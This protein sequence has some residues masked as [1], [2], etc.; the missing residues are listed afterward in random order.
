MLGGLDPIIIFDFYKLAPE[1]ASSVPAIPLAS[2]T[3]TRVNLPPIPI[4]LSEKLTGLYIDNEDK[5][6]DI[7]TDVETKSDAS[8]P[9]IQQKAINSVIR[10][11]MFANNESI[12]L[13]L[14]S[15][16]CDL[17]LPMATSQEYAVTYLHGAVTVF[18]GLINSFSISQNS[19]NDLFTVT[20]EITNVIR[21]TQVTSGP[22]DVQPEVNGEV[23]E[24]GAGPSPTGSTSPKMT[25][26]RPRAPS[27]PP[28]SMTRG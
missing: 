2:S 15:A 16:L 10:I 21:K 17:A 14:L 9:S 7:Q 22:P 5:S 23:L 18:R 13:T 4:Y 20:L 26:P 19:D 3:P 11:N 12:G 28:V 6:I 24:N 1:L 27:P 25:G 8:D